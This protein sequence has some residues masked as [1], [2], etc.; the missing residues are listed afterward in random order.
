MKTLTRIVSTTDARRKSATVL[1]ILIALL[2][3]SRFAIAETTVFPN[4]LQI[5]IVIK[6]RSAAV[7]ESFTSTA[8]AC[9]AITPTVDNASFLMSALTA[10]RAGTGVFTSF[11]FLFFFCIPF[12]SNSA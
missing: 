9:P 5:T 4:A 8:V 3:S 1:Q 6:I 11:P 2:P 10:S 12:A 7:M